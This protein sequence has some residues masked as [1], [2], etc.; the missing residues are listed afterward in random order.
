M[1]SSVV[2]RDVEGTESRGRRFS[3]TGEMDE[4]DFT[5]YYSGLDE[6]L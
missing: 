4:G 1:I 6:F 5:S 3:R 2:E